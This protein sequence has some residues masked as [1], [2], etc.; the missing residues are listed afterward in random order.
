MKARIKVEVTNIDNGKKLV[1]YHV[2][3]KKSFFSFWHT[4]EAYHNPIKA[5]AKLQQFLSITEQKLLIP[6]DFI[7]F[8]S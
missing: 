4:K 2:Q 5:V 8:D 6:K 3:I 1:F 7:P